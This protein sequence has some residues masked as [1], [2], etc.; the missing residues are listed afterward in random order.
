[1]GIYCRDKK[2]IAKSCLIMRISRM[3]NHFLKTHPSVSMYVLIVMISPYCHPWFL[4]EQ[5]RVLC[6]LQISTFEQFVTRAVGLNSQ[7]FSH[8]FSQCSNDQ[9][10]VFSGNIR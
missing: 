6:T 2:L 4:K 10:L 1:M 5:P 3:E 8:S 7:G 9:E